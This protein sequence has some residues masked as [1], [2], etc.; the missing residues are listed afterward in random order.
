MFPED[1]EIITKTLKDDPSP[2]NWEAAYEICLGARLD[3]R[4]LKPIEAIR[5]MRKFEGEGFLILTIQCSIIEFL[6]SLRLGLNFEN[7]TKWG[8]NFKYGESG[9][10]F[11]DFLRAQPPFSDHVRSE[12]DAVDFYLNIRCALVHEAQTK[13][14]WTVKAGFKR[15]PVIDFEKQIINRDELG[16][17]IEGYLKCYRTQLCEDNELQ[18]AFFRKFENLHGHMVNKSRGN[19]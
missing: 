3:S 8:V 18:E 13:N 5:K 9:K 16:R 2:A 7:R 14:G 12:A 17:A 6:A 19:K 11:K 4:Y 1:W 15:Y 10:L